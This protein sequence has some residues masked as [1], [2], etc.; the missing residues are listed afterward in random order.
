[1]YFIYILECKDKTY[2]TGIT[3]NVIERIEVH[4]SGKG[5]KYTRVRLPV[6]LKV[7]WEAKNRS[8]ASK[9]EIYIKKQKKIKKKEYIKN[10][11]TLIKEM[12]V[13]EINLK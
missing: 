2:Y 3:T 4:N 8:E 1:M 12:A 10:K 13:R 6:K 9:V 7:F 5:A 11:K